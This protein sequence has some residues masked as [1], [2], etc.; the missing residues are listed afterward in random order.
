MNLDRLEV[1]LRIVETGSMGAASRVLHLTQPALS[2]SLKLLEEELQTALFERRGRG[3]VLTA[4][5]RALEPRARAL[6]ES[7]QSIA[8]EVGRTAAQQYHD[9]RIGTIDSVATFLV[10]RVLP[11]V[12]RAF[13]ELA[14]KLTTARTLEL[15]RRVA[16][17]ELDA[18]I[19]AWS[20]VPDV[21]RA[22]R[23]GPY[24]LRF[25]GSKRG[26]PAL[27][28]A[29]T[30]AAVREFPIVE[31]EALPGQGSMIRKDAASFAIANSLA[32]VKAL[33]LA[34]FGVGA[35]LDFMLAPAERR[36]LVHARVPHD[37]DCA[38]YLVS[39]PTRTGAT[40]RRLD[41]ELAAALRA[42]LPVLK[43]RPARPSRSAARAAR[44]G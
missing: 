44:P 5:G 9:L 35:L 15:L 21:A 23:L 1:F 30:E 8:R 11:R 25:W 20:G 43:P 26:F 2:H 27:A 12:Q 13:P 4:A 39:A 33:V 22:E 16:T 34:G 3:L 29:T 19:V 28:R 31:I 14:I 24:T 32:S 10:P 42:A 38:L 18:A 37:P 36:T 17:S 7:A 6:L 40:E 41:L